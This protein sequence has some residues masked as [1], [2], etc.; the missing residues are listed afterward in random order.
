MLLN[1]A[2]TLCRDYGLIDNDMLSVYRHLFRGHRSTLS[3]IYDHED[4]M[5]IGHEGLATVVT[6]S[7]PGLR[8]WSGEFYPGCGTTFRES[9]EVG[10]MVIPHL[11]ELLSKKASNADRERDSE[12]RR[13]ARSS[14]SS[15]NPEVF[16]RVVQVIRKFE[17]AR[18]LAEMDPK[19]KYNQSAFEEAMKNV[20]EVW[21]QYNQGAF[22]EQTNEL[23][24]L[25]V[26]MWYW[27]ADLPGRTIHRPG[28]PSS[29]HF[30]FTGTTSTIPVQ[31][32]VA[33]PVF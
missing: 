27:D 9:P 24:D 17:Y 23:L 7:K 18:R 13:P 28:S 16:K 12:A 32:A 8:D 22:D 10:T 31:T 14:K 25:F 26:A 3:G 19:N 20:D 5:S 1:A 30:Q 4:I 11:P 6:S 29:N 15:P 21:G 33:T 2:S